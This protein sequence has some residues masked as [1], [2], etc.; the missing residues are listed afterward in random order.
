M[1]LRT[2]VRFPPSPPMGLADL[3]FPKFCL[4]CR[5]QGIYL[6]PDC[7]QKVGPGT[8]NLFATKYLNGVI[9]VW[10]YEGVVRKA[11]LALKYRFAKEVAQ[12]LALHF[13]LGLKQRWLPFG[14]ATL[15]P[16]PLYKKRQQ[17]RGF[18]QAEEMGKLVAEEMGWRFIPDLILREAAREPQTRLKKAQRIVNV[19]GIFAFNEKYPRSVVNRQPLVLFDDVVTT[20]ATLE[21]VARVLKHAGA[22]AVYGLTLAA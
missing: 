7:L 19:K 4:N 21:A 20:G 17:W 1:L 16:V 5:K 9:A 6:C 2:R 10:A 3:I 22:N 15:V 18:N 8:G 13:C 14:A 12:E 11:I